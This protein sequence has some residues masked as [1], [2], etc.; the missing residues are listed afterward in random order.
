MNITQER[1]S[2]LNALLKVKVEPQDYLP[3]YEKILK[4]YSKSMNIPGFR[5]GKVP[6]GIVKKR[7]GKGILAEEIQRILD[8]SISGYIKEKELKVLGQPLPVK[9]GEAGN[10]DQPSDFDF[11]FEIGLA[12]DFDLKLSDN[13]T[14]ESFKVKVD[15]KMIDEEVNRITR[16]YGKVEDVEKAGE[17]DLLV[18]DFVEVREDG[19]AKEEGIR[20]RST[21]GLEYVKDR[22]SKKR[23]VGL[24]KGDTVDVDPSKLASDHDDLGRMLGI[25]H[26][27]VHHLGKRAFKFEVNE[28]KAMTPAVMDEEFFGK[29]LPGDGEKSEKALRD[30]IKNEL[31]T[32][33]AKDTDVLFKRDANRYFSK[34]LK[35]SLPDTFLKKWIEMTNEGKMTPMDIETSYE[36]Y[37]NSIKWQL[38]KNKII[39]EEAI[40]VEFTEAMDHVKDLLSQN[41]KNYGMPIPGDEELQESAMRIMQNREE[42][43]RIFDNLYEEH[44]MKA[45]KEK[46]KVKVKEVSFD[47]F[48]EMAEK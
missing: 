31:D 16:R 45:L 1:L 34:K 27:E 32:H 11:T 7:Y 43:E 42:V 20:N 6:V 15:N 48:K 22:K 29:V 40:K 2:D 9:D 44:V 28:V 10:W 36:E 25:T 41:Y 17:N 33:F 39:T 26:E 47:K 4:D 35:L 46:T 8:D 5:A 30:F 38:I 24:K 14:L 18:G 37:S 12:P 21:I 13:Y 23:L 3:K 19:L